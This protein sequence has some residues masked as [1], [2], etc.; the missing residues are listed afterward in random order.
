MFRLF[1][2]MVGAK[3]FSPLPW[4]VV[5]HARFPLRYRRVAPSGARSATGDFGGFEKISNH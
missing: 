1:G 4:L 5:F 2:T 3:N